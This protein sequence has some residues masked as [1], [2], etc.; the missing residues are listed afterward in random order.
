MTK[1]QMNEAVAGKDVRSATSL[2]D[3]VLDGSVYSTSEANRFI[4]EEGKKQN[5]HKLLKQEDRQAPKY[6]RKGLSPT[7]FRGS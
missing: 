5:T 7:G 1:E 3:C 6:K 4:R 2:P